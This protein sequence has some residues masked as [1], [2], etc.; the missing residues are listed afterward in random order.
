MK[1]HE[2]HEH[3]ATNRP[4]TRAGQY[5]RDTAGQ[6]GEN[7]ERASEELEENVDNIQL[8]FNELRDSLIDK[9]K[10]YSRATNS[11]VSKNAWMA[12]GISAG[13]AF[14]AGMY[15]GWKRND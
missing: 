6:L 1:T 11:Y 5:L 10:E 15:V 12:M 3:P 2:R 7:A 8:K 14:V 4:I 13:L 9:T